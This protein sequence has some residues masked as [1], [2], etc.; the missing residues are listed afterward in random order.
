M[1]PRKGLDKEVGA[2][3]SFPAPTSQDFDIIFPTN[4]TPLHMCGI[5]LYF[6]VPTANNLYN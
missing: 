1:A 2:G 3:E 5:F 4:A 6:V